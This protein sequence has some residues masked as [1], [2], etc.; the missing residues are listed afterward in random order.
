MNKSAGNMYP[1]VDFTWNPVAGECPHKC[2]YCY[3]KSGFFKLLEKYQG[4]V[5]LSTRDFKP[6]GSGKTIFVCSAIDLFAN[7]VPDRIIMAVLNFCK[8]YDNTYLFQSKNP[9]RFLRF[10]KL[11]P[12]KVILGT[13]IETNR[14]YRIS[15]APPPVERAVAMSL[16]SSLGFR[17]MVSIEPIMDFDLPIMV[18]WMKSIKPEFVSIGADSKGFSLHEPKKDKVEDLI[19]ELSKF[20]E[21]KLK[22]NLKRM[23]RAGSS[24]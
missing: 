20:T 10:K 1:W 5:R 4:S 22:D 7:D 2:V 11:F 6:L 9:R 15:K 16:I 12:R 8:K 24:T 3:V 14:D 18:V 23:M 21:V 17:T 13:T 19:N